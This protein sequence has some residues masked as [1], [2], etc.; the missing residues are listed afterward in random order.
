[1]RTEKKPAKNRRQNIQGETFQQ[2]L[3]TP[4]LLIKGNSL[5]VVLKH[6]RFDIDLVSESV[7]A[8]KYPALIASGR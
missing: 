4:T 1:M 5:R 6:H 3:D 8:F 2:M 7:T